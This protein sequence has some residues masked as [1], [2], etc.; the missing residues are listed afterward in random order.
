[1]S[2]EEQTVL[3][4]STAQRDEG[5]STS[6]TAAKRT[7]GV[8]SSVAI[9]LLSVCFVLSLSSR[10]FRDGDRR[11]NHTNHTQLLTDV[12]VYVPNIALICVMLIGIIAIVIFICRKKELTVDNEGCQLTRKHDLHRKYSFRSIAI[13]FVGVCILDMNYI[14]VELS[15]IS[16]WFDCDNNKLLLDN[17]VL[18]VFHFTAMVGAIVEIVVCWTMKAKNFKPSQRVWH[19]L[20]FVLAANITMWFQSLLKESYRRN[21]EHDEQGGHGHSLN[22]Y[23]S[24]CNDYTHKNESSVQQKV[25]HGTLVSHVSADS[26]PDHNRI[27]PAGDGNFT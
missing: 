2:A 26:F 21:E 15:C 22:G 20:A 10:E 1:M 23:F 8:S 4:A 16:N 9:F 11:S 7:V 5:P 3:T 13:F 24:F 27:Q 18:T 19:L 12:P 6:R 14:I 25:Q 17:V